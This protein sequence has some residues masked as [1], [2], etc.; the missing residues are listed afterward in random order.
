MKRFAYL[1]PLFTIVLCG[2]VYSR[3]DMQD[4]KNQKLEQEVLKVE[5]TRLEAFAKGDV[6]TLDRIFAD[7][8]AYTNVNG[9]NHT[10]EELIA[11][12]RSGNLK[13]TSMKHSDVHVRIYENTA[14]LTGKS[15]STYIS[16][17]K[18]GGAPRSYMNVYF[19]NNGQWRLV[20]RQ[21]TPILAK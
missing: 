1:I 12:V 21:E 18:A 15:A 4:Q 17:G 3:A 7:D 14:V 13:Y 19:K 11:D 5:E 9:E 8:F 6:A 10:K 16:G 20:A 2:V